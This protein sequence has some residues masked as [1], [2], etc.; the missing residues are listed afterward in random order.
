MNKSGKS[1]KDNC[2]NG[3]M[4]AAN[5]ACIVP[6]LVLDF[7]TL[8]KERFAAAVFNEIGIYK[9][10]ITSASDS[11]KKADAANLIHDLNVMFYS[12]F[13]ESAE[14]KLVEKSVSE[15]LLTDGSVVRTDGKE[16]LLAKK[17]Y[18][19]VL[20]PIIDHKLTAE[21]L[22]P[23]FNSGHFK[24]KEADLQN[25]AIWKQAKV[26]AEMMG[27]SAQEF[28]SVHTSI[29]EEDALAAEMAGFSVTRNKSD[30]LIEQ[31]VIYSSGDDSIEAAAQKIANIRL[32]AESK[33]DAI[34]AELDKLDG[35]CRGTIVAEQVCTIRGITEKRI[36][37]EEA[38]RLAEA[39]P[40][41][42]QEESN[43]FRNMV[44]DSRNADELAVAGRG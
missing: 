8:G 26:V 37:R 3:L 22:D 25:T 21:H 27:G 32:G 38:R 5:I 40:R 44:T 17:E 9:N 14:F 20:R 2:I 13:K 29:A 15:K 42:E 34:K 24:I 43:A 11:D 6:A 31:L 30:G 16:G 35:L 23:E 19:V 36:A 12:A 4:I 18:F 33:S 1:I 41:H 28:I 10:R 7:V 39:E